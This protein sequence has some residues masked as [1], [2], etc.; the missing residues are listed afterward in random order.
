MGD[1]M[2]QNMVKKM[3][4]W[5]RTSRMVVTLPLCLG[6]LYSPANL[7]KSSRTMLQHRSNRQPNGAVASNCQQ[8]KIHRH[9]TLGTR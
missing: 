8:P 6:V 7:D 5:R 1:K 4:G 9:P 3:A 2:G